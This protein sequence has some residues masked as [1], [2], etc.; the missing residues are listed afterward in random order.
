[1]RLSTKLFAT[2]L[3][4]SVILPFSTPCLADGEES[5]NQQI[6]A[7]LYSETSS[8]DSEEAIRYLSSLTRDDLGPKIITAYA[9]ALQEADPHI[10]ANASRGFRILSK[11][12]SEDQRARLLSALKSSALEDKLPREV[13]LRLLDEWSVLAPPEEIITE[14]GKS[15]TQSSHP[16]HRHPV[17]PLY[18][19]ITPENRPILERSVPYL[20]SLAGSASDS[21]EDRRNAVARLGLLGQ[22][23]IKRDEIANALS[24]LV[25]SEPIPTELKVS[26]TFRLGDLSAVKE[27]HAEF[28]IS[29]IKAS[30]NSDELRREALLALTPFSYL[31][32]EAQKAEIRK[33]ALESFFHPMDIEFYF[34]GDDFK[35]ELV[36]RILSRYQASRDR[37]ERGRLMT[38]LQLTLRSDPAELDRAFESLLKAELSAPTGNPDQLLCQSIC[39]L[40]ESAP[41]WLFDE[42]ETPWTIGGTTSERKAKATNLFYGGAFVLKASRLCPGDHSKTLSE[43]KRRLKELFE[44]RPPSSA[45]DSNPLAD[46]AQPPSCPREDSLDRI[47]RMMTDLDLSSHFGIQPPNQTFEES[48]Y[49]G[50]GSGEYFD[51]FARQAAALFHDMAKQTPS[52]QNDES[53]S[54]VMRALSRARSEVKKDLDVSMKR[55][56]PSV[57][58]NGTFVR[59]ALLLS[60]VGADPSMNQHVSVRELHALSK[61]FRDAEPNFPYDPTELANVKRSTPNQA[62]ARNVGALLVLNRLNLATDEEVWKGLEV[63]KRN[64]GNMRDHLF[65]DNHGGEN[66]YHHGFFYP[67]VIFAADQLN[68]L[69]KDYRAQ[70]GGQSDQAIQAKLQKVQEMRSFLISR[71]LP[72]YQPDKM[73]LVTGI[74][75]E[76]ETGSTIPWKNAL[77]GLGMISLAGGS[78]GTISASNGFL[79]D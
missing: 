57:I 4:I 31:L 28:L 35:N 79:S 34:K 75:A 5:L 39:G 12:M 51:S 1:M 46:P 37:Q 11:A 62:A 78:C 33:H 45:D 44:F 18:F 25:L 8:Y 71:V 9:K 56:H 23:G 29:V 13:R 74:P 50:Y 24:D 16:F 63:L 15:I 77:G 60:L 68:A 61:S 10:Q 22:L 47:R 72:L 76:A 2:L 19:S 21:I 27:P 6:R 43:L 69:E 70:L 52:M 66:S 32:S 20:L 3:P 73:Q 49:S 41:K 58:R 14:F 38:T 26:A 30:R 64:F 36:P 55:P 53:F 59:S 65:G 54:E 48:L 17:L 7:S 67:S 40:L 42:I